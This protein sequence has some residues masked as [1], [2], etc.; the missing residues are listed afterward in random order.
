VYKGSNAARGADVGR[1]LLYFYPV[2]AEIFKTEP[3]S[4]STFYLSVIL[5]LNTSDDVM[6]EKTDWPIPA[7]V[8]D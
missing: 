1:N 3:E 8:H 2:L 4:P 7:R 6:C 5:N